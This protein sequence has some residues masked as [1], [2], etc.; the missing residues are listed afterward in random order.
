MTKPIRIAVVGDIHLAFDE[1][2]VRA[3]DAAGYDLLL[4]V[5]DLAGYRVGGGLEVARTIAKVRTR[6]LVIPG[7]H[8]AVTGA[9]LASEIFSAPEAVRDALSIGMEER[10]D[11]LA[12]ALA[13]VPLV[14]YALH[15]IDELGL[16]VLSARP[17]SIGGPRI[18]FRR[19]LDARFGVGSIEASAA[20]LSSLFDQ[21]P[22]GERILVLAHN[23]PRGLGAKRSDL[24][25]CDFRPEEGDFGDGDLEAALAHAGRTG[26]SVVAVIAGHM[27]HRLRGGGQRRW[28]ETRDG[29]TFVNAAATPR[30][31][32]GES[33]DEGHH[34]RVVLEPG[35]VRVEEAWEPL[36]G[37]RRG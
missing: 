11:A 18:A 2:E 26:K 5:G 34:V 6:A 4:F 31:R 16:T 28:L 7:N 14:G 25:G 22:T 15:R 24:F 9:Q 10:V 29:I 30:R 37:P 17:H 33:G 32:S 23:G 19:Y 27:H 12:R 1:R 13:P 8:D 21:V 3:L 35:G 36:V 20:R